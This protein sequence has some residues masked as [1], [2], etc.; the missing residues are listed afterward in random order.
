MVLRGT[1]SPMKLISPFRSET[2]S[3]HNCVAEPDPS[4]IKFGSLSPAELKPRT[5]G[6]IIALGAVCLAALALPTQAGADVGASNVTFFDA[7]GA[8][9]ITDIPTA[10]SG[11]AYASAASETLPAWE[12]TVDGYLSGTVTVSQGDVII[13]AQFINAA[14]TATEDD[15]AG[16]GSLDLN[17]ALLPATKLTIAANPATLNLDSYSSSPG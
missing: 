10:Y 12:L 15:V 7:G 4:S 6:G 9:I 16:S 8:E 3:P 11:L 1:H 13:A 5:L 17:G 14:E 2:K